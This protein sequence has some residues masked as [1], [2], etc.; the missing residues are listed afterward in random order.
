ML[1]LINPRF[2][3]T[4]IIS[5]FA[6][7][8]LPIVALHVFGLDKPL[9]AAIVSGL[10]WALTF[11]LGLISLPKSYTWLAKIYNRIPFLKPIL[12]LNGTWHVKIESNWERI[13]MLSDQHHEPT[14]TVPLKP[15]MGTL[16]LKCNIFR[17]IGRFRVDD[18]NS[19]RA[20]RTGH[21]DI[22]ASSLRVEHERYIFSYIAEASVVNPDPNTDEQTFL[23][24]AE[25]YFSL[26]ELD[27]GNGRYWTNR[28]YV[29]GQNAAGEITL[30]R[31]CV[32]GQVLNRESSNDCIRS[33]KRGE[34][35]Q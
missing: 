30:S 27:I 23:F 31:K 20:S 26:D 4:L 29:T 21:S 8:L 15:V 32:V 12:N 3:L 19:E 22:V 14:E 2:A 1:A 10:P 25:V 5:L 7:T 17:T 28:K 13:R 33:K 18:V 35:K 24:A 9:W 6:L 16:T 34:F 11:T